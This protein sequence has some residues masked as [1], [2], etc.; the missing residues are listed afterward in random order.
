MLNYVIVIPARLKSKRLPNKPLIKIKGIPM[1][2][3]TYN[4]C[5]KAAYRDRI[6]VATDS[7]KIKKICENNKIKV[8]LT[9]KN[10][11]TGTDR[12]AE[13]SKK[14]K[15]KVYINIQGD[16]PIFNPRDIKKLIKFSK[17]HPTD[18]INGYS[19]ILDKK[20]FFDE[21]IP[22]VLFSKKKELIYMSRAPIPFN[23][24]KKFFW[25]YRQICAYS[26]PYKAL[27]KFNKI[28]KKSK[29]ESI[30]DLELL[31]FIEMGIKIRM[32]EMS[33][34]SLA[35]DTKSDLKKINKILK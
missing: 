8:V 10:C 33:N 28:K 32:I 7:N 29:I 19:K 17:K 20:D 14:I 23:K 9:S 5:L 12:I 13:F 30:E 21:N 4:Q 1:I 18:V 6:Y 11:L 35:I 26:L 3:R 24:K 31:R 27:L 25:A 34:K 16:E 15:S 2:V 22:K